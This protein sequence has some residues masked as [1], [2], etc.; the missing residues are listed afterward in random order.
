MNYFH[1]VGAAAAMVALNRHQVEADGLR[2][3]NDGS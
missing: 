3:K 1:Y 2:V